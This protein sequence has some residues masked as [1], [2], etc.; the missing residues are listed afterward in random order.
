[1]TYRIFMEIDR[2]ITD[3]TAVCVYPW[4]RPLLEEVHGS[5]AT[6]VTI[7]QMCSKDGVVS[8]KAIKMPT[9]APDQDGNE[10]VPDKAPDL[11]AQLT[12]MTRVPRDTDPF[13]DLGAEW[14]RLLEKYGMHP[15]VAVPVAEKVFGTAQGFRR[16][17]QPYRA[18]EPPAV[19]PIYGQDADLDGDPA[20]LDEDKAPADMSRDELKAALK[21]RGIAIKGNPSEDT[22]REMLTDA[23]AG[24][25]A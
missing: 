11:R 12:A 4:E 18:S 22:L 16:M 14:G 8:V 25:E 10:R 7:D 17:V 2:G 19:D 3:K 23:I 20:E 13:N 24:F 15:T 5:G 9:S 21:S 1:V 6:V